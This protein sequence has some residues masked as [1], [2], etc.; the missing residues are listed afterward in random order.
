ML[1]FCIACI[2]TQPLYVNM[3]SVQIRAYLHIRTSVR[4][5]ISFLHVFHRPDTKGVSPP[6][7]METFPDKFVNPK[8][9]RQAREISSTVQ[10]GPKVSAER[11]IAR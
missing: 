4:V 1:K 9:F 5:T 11:S 10:K 6:P 8:T 3:I 2:S 7:L